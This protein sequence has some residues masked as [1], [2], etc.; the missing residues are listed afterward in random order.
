MKRQYPYLKDV[1][2]L[3]L[4]YGQHNQT[5]YT[6]ITVLD[7]YERPLDTVEGRVLSG[8]ISV[9][10][11]SA[12]RRTANLSVKIF[13]DSELYNN[14]D[15]LF[16]INKKIFI[17]TGLKNNYAHLGADYYPDYSTVWFPFGVFIITA[18]SVVHDLT[19]I[20]VSLTLSDKMSLLN[21]TAGGVIPASTNF[22]S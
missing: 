14:I 15:S 17:E 22:E 18:C 16:S 3:D 2:F 9:N 12:V 21:G 11:D 20:T 1:P 13:D 7:W 5:T 4:I 19:G 10:G 8:S 6:R